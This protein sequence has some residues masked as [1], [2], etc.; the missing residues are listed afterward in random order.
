MRIRAALTSAALAFA[1]S[2]QGAQGTSAGEP[3]YP[4]RPVRLVIAN[5]PGS[6]PDAVGRMIGAKLG[7]AWGQ[8]VVVDNR[9]GATGLIAAEVTANAPPDGYTL[10]LPTMTQLIATLQA[11]RLMLERDFAPVA[12]V[13]TTP[14]V[15][16]VDAS[17]P[18]KSIAD[19]IAY[20]KGRPGQLFFGSEGQWGSTHL[21][22]EFLNARAGIKVDHVPYKGTAL[23]MQ[24]LIGGRIQAY[25]PA[26]PSLPAVVQTGKVRA[27]A[28]TYPKPTPLAP[29]LPPVADTIPG[30]ELFGWYSLEAP[31]RTPQR[32]T[33][34]IS[35]DL[36]KALKHP[37]LREQLNKIGAEAAGTSPAELGRFLHDQTARWGKILREGGAIP[38]K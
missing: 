31:R 33:E 32:V 20:A 13:A 28:V 18:V 5:T 4:V 24:D 36:A 19:W 3:A 34:K 26:A 2:A 23:V 30:F 12:L 22:M 29:G 14:F 21:C 9:P 25:C 7:E 10:W 8:Q 35:A 16:V 38:N 6:A 1:V 11:Q 37:Q 15:I 27:L 17:L